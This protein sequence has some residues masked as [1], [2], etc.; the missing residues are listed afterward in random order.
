LSPFS[1]SW[2]NSSRITF[3]TKGKKP[4][5]HSCVQIA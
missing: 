2:S 4:A 1:S 5:F 3:R